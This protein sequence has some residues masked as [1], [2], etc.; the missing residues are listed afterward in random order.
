MTAEENHL[1]PQL[2]KRFLL[3]ET[4]PAENL[5]VV[6]HLIGG[7]RQTEARGR[8]DA[9]LTVE[10]AQPGQ[11]WGGIMAPATK[12]PA[13]KIRAPVVHEIETLLSLIKA[14]DR[15]VGSCA[16]GKAEPSGGSKPATVRRPG[17]KAPARRRP[18]AMVTP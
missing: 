1:D 6:K 12:K 15:A 8:E 17:A 2:L 5:V 11:T 13:K 14:I 9:T 10:Q 3:G 16:M 18:K 4:N 7:F